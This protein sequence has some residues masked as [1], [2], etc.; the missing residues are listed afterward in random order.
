MSD[1]FRMAQ[2]IGHPRGTG[3]ITLDSY[4][5]LSHVMVS[6]RA[7]F[8]SP[9][10]DVLAGIGRTRNVS[11]TVPSYNQVALVLAQTDCVATLPSRLLARYGTLVDVV[12]LPFDMPPFEFAM[13]W[14][15]RSQRDPA[16]QWLRDRFHEAVVAERC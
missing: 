3:A 8:H 13:G 1:R 12:D 9:L 7:E 15:P 10:D 5:Q 4:C 14:H 16:L 2:R 6:Q 11:V